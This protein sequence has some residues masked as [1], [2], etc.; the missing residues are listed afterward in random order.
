M[1]IL[2]ADDH[3]HM[4][5]IIIKMLSGLPFNI[6]FFECSD[7]LDAITAITAQNPDIVLMDLLM[8]KMDGFSAIKILRAAGN[9]AIIIVVTQFAESEF[10]EEVIRL[11]ADYFLNKENLLSLPKIITDLFYK[12]K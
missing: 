7:G 5:G 10:K 8:K 6:D 3:E 2:I 11:G 1:K 4:R 9:K 12:L